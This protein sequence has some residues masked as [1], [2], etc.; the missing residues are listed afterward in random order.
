[1]AAL[2]SRFNVHR[3]KQEWMDFNFF[4]NGSSY[5]EQPSKCF[6]DQLSPMGRANIF[7]K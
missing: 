5:A 4:D 2:V 1:M 6:L 3:Y 7:P